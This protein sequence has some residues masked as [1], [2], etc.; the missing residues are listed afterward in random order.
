[1]WNSLPDSV[2]ESVMPLLQ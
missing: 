1:M 2:V